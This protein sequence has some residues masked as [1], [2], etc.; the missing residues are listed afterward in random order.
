MSHT[1]DEL[2]P[3]GAYKDIIEHF[4]RVRLIPV[5]SFPS[6][7]EA[8]LVG[9]AL[10]DGGLPCLE[11]T[12]RTEAAEEA[13][14]RLAEELPEMCLGA[15]TI[16]HLQQAKRA[17][18]AGARFLVS[19]GLDPDIIEWSLREGVPVFP[20]VLTPTEITCAIHYGLEVLKFFPAE[21]S[22]GVS[23]LKALSGPFRTVKF[24]PTGGITAENA[25]DYF[26]LPSVLAC[27]GSWL[28]KGKDG[29][30]TYDAVLQRVKAVLKGISGS[31]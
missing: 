9:T 20:G 21:A 14:V 5:G 17:V 3:E 24:I 27:G 1:S 23:F 10:K 28:T 30:D 6:P 13:I 7:E 16:L 18:D 25:M 15:G 11:V 22:G 29:A 2:A 19:P 12:F 8:L 4:K 26:A 31:S